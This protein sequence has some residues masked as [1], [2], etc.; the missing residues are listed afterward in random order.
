M[1]SELGAVLVVGGCGFLGHHI[2]TRL[3][4]STSAQVSVFDLRPPRHR[5]SSVSYYDGDITSRAAVQRVL[6]EVKPHVII[7]TASPVAASFK[8]NTALYE[9]V[10]V[11]GTRNLLECAGESGSVK[12]FVYTS[13][14]S[15]VHDSASDLVDGDETLPVLRSPQQT[16]IYSHTKG[17]ADDLVLSA[18]RKYGDM[19][20]LSIRPASMFG[21]WDVQLL[22]NMLNVYYTGKT[23]VQLGDNKNRFD[24]TYVGN[25]AHAHVL[26][27]Q[28]LLETHNFPE[29][30]GSHGRVDGEAFLVTNDEPYCFWD[31]AHEVWT[32]AGAKVDPKE[33]WVIPKNTALRMAT[34]LEWIFWFLFLGTKEPSFTRQKAKWSCM[35][36][37][38]HI[39]KA[40]ARL[41][42]KPL[43]SVTEGIQ[44]GVAWFEETRAK[45]KK[46]Q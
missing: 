16:E 23:K 45:D 46:I 34:I 21:E 20:T 6:R 43:W 24:F 1:D 35:T 2:V 25:A 10:N 14:A 44:R 9:K 37:T 4:Q 15:V 17:I 30:P 11:E 42:Y 5:L 39:D 8:G 22:P 7:H 38:F 41:G 29:R 18:N 36:R 13:S 3:L 28:K 26:G 12:A 27:A 33:I 32:T 40:K 31:F 19:L